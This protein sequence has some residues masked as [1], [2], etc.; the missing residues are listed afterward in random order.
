MGLVGKTV[1]EKIWNFFYE[2]IKNAFGTAGLMGN[3]QKESGLN[4]KNLQNSFQAKLGHTDDSYTEAV[5][6]GTYTNFVRD[7]AGYGLAQFTFWTRK[8]N[9]LN[10]VRSKKVS[11]GDLETQL[12]FIWK[13]LSESYKS[14]LTALQ[15]ATSV[16]AAS[17]IVLTKY[18]R[19]ADQ[20]VAEQEERADYG[21]NFYQKYANK[22]VASMGY[23]N[24]PLVD[25]KVMSPNHS[26]TRTH[27]IDRI[28]PHCVV[29]QLKAENIGGCFTKESRKASCN[30]GIGTD[31]RVCLIVDEAN[32]SWCSSSSA[33]DQRAI[34]IECASD[35]VEP[36]AMNT[37]V[38][39]KLIQLCV[40]I[41]KRNGKNTLLWID[42]KDKALSYVPKDN[43]MLLTVHRWFANKSCPGNWLYSRLGNVA[44]EVTALL[45]GGK[46]EE[47]PEVKKTLYRVQVGA[48]S[49]KANADAQLKK[50]KAKGFTDAFITQ[51]GNLYKV[52][53]G[54]YSVKANADNML[55]KVKAAGFDAFITTQ[56]GT[57]VSASAAEPAKTV[58]AGSTVRVKNGAK[59]YTGG[60]LASFVYKRDHQ[61]KEIKGDRAVITYKGTVVAAVKVSDLTPV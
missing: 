12:L 22:E 15:T 42:N 26:G 37:A 41:C 36:Y 56:S 17:D 53:V 8:Q 31:G 50:V 21:L 55:K 45:N 6:N 16:R 14:V 29:G 33:N 38:Y 58:K 5:D 57:A 54:A 1:E 39:N 59:T 23:T 28:T 34:T 20:G 46:A 43:E 13:E 4:P 18:E 49:K 11:V 60:N 7:S 30:Y 47:E 2:R 10:F 24:S 3:L 25:C 27:K 32:R 9:L 61:V 40:D 51:V 52:Q 35:K 48:Y 44:K 19:P